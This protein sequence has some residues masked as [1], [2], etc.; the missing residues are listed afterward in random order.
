MRENRC[1][2]RVLGLSATPGVDGSKVQVRTHTLVELRVLAR[3]PLPAMPW[4]WWWCCCM[5]SLAP[6][7]LQSC[8]TQ[9]SALLARLCV[10]QQAGTS[11]PPLTATCRMSRS[12]LR[13]CLHPTQ[14]VITNLNIAAMEF[15]TEEDRDVAPYTHPKDIQGGDSRAEVDGGWRAWGQHAPLPGSRES[16][17]RCTWCMSLL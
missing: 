15:R 6:P 16:S 8:L 9:G 12:S 5:D 7:G 14:E 10:G 13:V 2:F 11:A 1:K 4:W 3:V 17:V